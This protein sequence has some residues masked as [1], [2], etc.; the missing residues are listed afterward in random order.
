[1]FLALM[2]WIGRSNSHKELKQEELC[3]NYAEF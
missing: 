2:E 1:M 3:E